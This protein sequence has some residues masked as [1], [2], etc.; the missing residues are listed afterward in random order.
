MKEINGIGNPKSL[1]NF[2]VIGGQGVVNI[3]E[4]NKESNLPWTTAKINNVIEASYKLNDEDNFKYLRN[5]VF[6]YL[7]V[8]NITLK[9]LKENIHNKTSDLTKSQRDFVLNNL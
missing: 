4:K 5:F 3:V 8:N 2:N 9:Q 6:T 7:R 1:L